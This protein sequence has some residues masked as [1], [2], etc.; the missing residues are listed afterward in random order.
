[1]ATVQRART[2]AGAEEWVPQSFGE[3]L[4]NSEWKAKFLT[5]AAA[6]VNSTAVHFLYAIDGY[7]LKCSWTEADRIRKEY[8]GQ[9]TWIQ[10][11]SK[12]FKDKMNTL[13]LVEQMAVPPLKLFDDLYQ[14]TLQMLAPHFAPFMIQM[15]Y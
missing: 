5:Y 2:N 1:V 13:Q 4:A 14:M 11:D 12:K 15:G 9:V 3:L 8:F 6:S 7:K 10:L